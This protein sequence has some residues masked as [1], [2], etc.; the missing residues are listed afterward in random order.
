MPLETDISLSETAIDDLFHL[1]KRSDQLLEIISS[2]SEVGPKATL[3]ELAGSTADKVAVQK[4]EVQRILRSILN[5]YELG[6]DLKIGPESLVNA[7]TEKIASKAAT[8]KAL[9]TW[10]RATEKIIEA[11]RS[12]NPDHAIVITRKANRIVNDHEH[13]FISAK[14]IT[15]IRPIFNT[16]GD[17]IIQ[18]LISHVL[19]IHYRSGKDHCDIQ[20]ALD[21]NDVSELKA[22][23]ERAE[24]KALVAKKDL[25]NKWPTIIFGSNPDDEP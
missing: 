25:K 11:I 12:L 7:L 13:L 21:A 23:C 14:I 19:S 20:F 10:R 22:L 3:E 6:L 5:V 2:A 24:R 18:S 15:D 4:T 8:A 1:A 9:E 16:A 17:K